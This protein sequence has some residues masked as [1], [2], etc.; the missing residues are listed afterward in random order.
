[1]KRRSSQYD[2]PVRTIYKGRLSILV[3]TILLLLTSP[4]LPVATASSQSGEI[5]TSCNANQECHYSYFA[6]PHATRSAKPTW[7]H[8]SSFWVLQM[9]LCDSGMAGCYHR[10][11]G[12]PVPEAANI[13][14]SHEPD[15]VTLNE[16][17]MDDWTTLI[18]VMQ[19][20]YP[21]DYVGGGGEGV[22]DRNTGGTIQCTGGRGDYMDAVIYR[23]A[24]DEAP[25]NTIGYGGRYNSSIQDTTHELRGFDCELVPSAD[26]MACTTHLSAAENY[27]AFEQCQNLMN[28]K[29]PSVWSEYGQ[30]PT[31][32]AGDLNL[33]QDD[34]QDYN[35]QGC[36]PPGWYR[37][38]D[39]I[40][41][42]VMA[43]S[44]FTYDFTN[45]I[46]MQHT[47]HPAL[48]VGLFYP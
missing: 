18:Q 2:R 38:G 22:G 47:D 46:D 35:A 11:N 5:R 44:N 4:S 48:L 42:H 8:G 15:V 3:A 1:M 29:I 10:N 33:Y 30:V 13:I 41:Q 37:K 23:V 43:T 14:T 45:T 24:P 7:P 36:V 32:M 27:T 34:P 19:N 40:V 39:G 6:A 20:L 26:F 28:V 9:N 17:C 31:V 12:D 25:G 21:G 16:V